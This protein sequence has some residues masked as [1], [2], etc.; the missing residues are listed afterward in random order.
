MGTSV[1]RTHRQHPRRGMPR[2]AL[3]R[4]VRS[5]AA[6]HRVAREDSRRVRD[7]DA[8]HA[9]ARRRRVS[10]HVPP[11]RV[12]VAEREVSRHEVETR[13]RRRGLLR[14]REASPRRVRPRRR[15][16]AAAG[17]PE[18]SD[19]DAVESR[20]DVVDQ[21]AREEVEEVDAVPRGRVDVDV[22]L[23]DLSS[24]TCRGSIRR[25]SAGSFLD[26][27]VARH[28]VFEAARRARTRR[29]T[30]AR[31]PARRASAAARMSS[32]EGGRLSSRHQQKVLTDD[33]T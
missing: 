23:I 33:E 26:L 19:G 7:R 25:A 10:Q 22:D 3:V 16:H 9:P 15:A 29:R 4:D 31:E 17:H 2:V 11:P 8:V 5:P 13:Q 14:L 1:R 27:T 24:S 21:R 30:P 32:G 20:D 18:A 6:E 12:E 28:R